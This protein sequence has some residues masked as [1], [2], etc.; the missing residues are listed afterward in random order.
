MWMLPVYLAHLDAADISGSPVTLENSYSSLDSLSLA[1][2]CVAMWRIL[3]KESLGMR[4]VNRTR[5]RLGVEEACMPVAMQSPELPGLGVTCGGECGA[6]ATAG[7]EIEIAI[8]I[9]A[10]TM[11]Q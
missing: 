2:Q 6:P 1:K 8:E 4:R 10:Q 9:D 5:Q 11:S 7:R 3:W